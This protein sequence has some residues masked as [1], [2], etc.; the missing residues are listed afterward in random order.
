MD[1]GWWL[2]V[3]G[4]TAAIFG[5]GVV[6]GWIIGDDRRRRK[7]HDLYNEACRG[8]KECHQQLVEFQGKY[9]ITTDDR[10]YWYEQYQKK[11]QT[12]IDDPD[13]WKSGGD[14]PY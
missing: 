10:N 6:F 7:C 13:W 4:F 14:P 9:K 3:L 5:S 12:R 8:W 2:T 11:C 1:W